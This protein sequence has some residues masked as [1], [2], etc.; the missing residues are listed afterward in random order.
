MVAKFTQECNF[1][2]TETG[3]QVNQYALGE[4]L[5]SGAFSKV[6]SGKDEEG[7]GY[8]IKV[9]LK[10]G[11][12]KQSRTY[13]NGPALVT[14]NYLEMVYNEIMI[15]SLLEHENIVQLLEIIDSP[16]DSNLYL[17]METCESGQLCQWKQT[18]GKY[19]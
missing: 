1:K 18:D 17:V 4:T 12:K 7:K 13:Y 19:Y 9:M 3:K 15:H 5:G 16:K 6:K 2:E 8:A 10:A 14:S 11:L